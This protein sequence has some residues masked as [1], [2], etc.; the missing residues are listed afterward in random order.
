[1]WWVTTSLVGYV[2]VVLLRREYGDRSKFGIS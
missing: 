2:A 1:L